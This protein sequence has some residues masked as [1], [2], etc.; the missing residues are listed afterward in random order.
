MNHVENKD[1]KVFSS[2]LHPERAV[3][4]HGGGGVVFEAFRSGP[5]V[6][7]TVIRPVGASVSLS[8]K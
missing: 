8:I 3:G 5:R 4:A 7:G 1:K 6:P 2:H